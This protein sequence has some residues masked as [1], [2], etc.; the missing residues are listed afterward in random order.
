[1]TQTKLTSTG[2]TEAFK[3]TEKTFAPTEERVLTLIRR[4]YHG[5]S[6]EE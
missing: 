3:T 2:K 4:H 6:C 5:P 1:M